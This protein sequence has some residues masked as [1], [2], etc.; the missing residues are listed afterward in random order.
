[1]LGIVAKSGFEAVE[2]GRRISLIEGV[3]RFF[4]EC[5]GAGFGVHGV[6]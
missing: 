5:G 1:V 3:V 2:R 6:L 4:D